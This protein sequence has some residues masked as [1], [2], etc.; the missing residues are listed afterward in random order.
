MDCGLTQQQELGDLGFRVFIQDQDIPTKVKYV[1]N[2]MER[3]SERGEEKLE[4]EKEVVHEIEMHQFCCYYRGDGL[5]SWR[6]LLHHANWKT[7]CRFLQK[8][9][10]CPQSSINFTMM[11]NKIYKFLKGC[12]GKASRNPGVIPSSHKP[13]GVCCWLEK[14]GLPGTSSRL[15]QVA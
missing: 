8:F 12:L 15:S 14:Q 11:S 4:R 5:W 6:Q 13:L 9:L 2:K 10:L 3:R 7:L 1:S